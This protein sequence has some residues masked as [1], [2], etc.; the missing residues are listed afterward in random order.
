MIARTST[1]ACPVHNML[2]YLSSAKIAHDSNEY[3]FRDITKD[4]DSSYHLSVK[5]KPLSYTLARDSIRKVTWISSILD[6]IA[7]GRE[8][9]QQQQTQA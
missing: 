3:I 7:Y 9:A 4:K 8:D 1:I 5:G 2:L 6:Y